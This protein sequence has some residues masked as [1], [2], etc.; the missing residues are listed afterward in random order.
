MSLLWLTARDKGLEK[1]K[2]VAG[3]EAFSLGRVYI[4]FAYKWGVHLWHV[5]FKK[6]GVE[7]AYSQSRHA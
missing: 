1:L 6:E 4:K 2:I 5:V 3:A 7:R